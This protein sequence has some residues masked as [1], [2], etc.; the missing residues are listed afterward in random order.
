MNEIY[1][2]AVPYSF[3]YKNIY[4]RPALN[5]WVQIYGLGYFDHETK[6][7]ESDKRTLEILIP[8]SISQENTWHIVFVTHVN[9]NSHAVHARCAQRNMIVVEVKMEGKVLLCLIQYINFAAYKSSLSLIEKLDGIYMKNGTNMLPL[10]SNA[11]M[12]VYKY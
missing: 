8:W 7:E 5:F 12:L 10:N 11:C 2:W 6:I 3:S 9:V 4:I 1:V